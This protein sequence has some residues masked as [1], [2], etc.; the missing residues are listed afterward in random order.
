MTDN[1]GNLAVCWC[2]LGALDRVTGGDIGLWSPALNALKSYLGS[3]NIDGWNDAP[4]RTQAEVVQALR[5]A[6][7][8]HA[9]G[10]Q[11]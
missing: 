6:A 4:E 5:A 11:S 7:Q 3:P 2:T 9:Q 8:S 1:C 10:V